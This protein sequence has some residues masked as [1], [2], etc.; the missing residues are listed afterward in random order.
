MAYVL[1]M[2]MEGDFFQ[3]SVATKRRENGRL[4]IL[5][6]VPGIVRVVFYSD[7][8]IVIG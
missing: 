7:Y 3:N 5:F 6:Y 4:E 1:G 8:S 2:R